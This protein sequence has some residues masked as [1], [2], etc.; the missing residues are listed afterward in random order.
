M[1]NTVPELLYH[2]TDYVVLEGILKNGIIRLCRSD[3]MNDSEEMKYFIK[4]LKE[5]TILKLKQAN[6]TENIIN[7]FEK[8]YEKQIKIRKKYICYLFSMTSLS[9]NA[10]Y[11]ERYGNH[12]KGIAIVFDSKVLKEISEEHMLSLKPVLYG[13]SAISKHILIQEVIDGFQKKFPTKN[14]LDDLKMIYD[15]VLA[16][17]IHFKN[18]S[19]FNEY[20][21]RL[22]SIPSWDDEHFR[23]LKLEVTT[24]ATPTQ[25]NKKVLLFNWKQNCD[26]KNIPYDKLINK[27]IIG[28]NSNQEDE[29]K[30][31]LK[32]NNL[33]CLIECVE[34]S[35]TP[36]Q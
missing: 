32:N 35:T 33:E 23:K 3:E 26:K 34:R 27:I 8:E 17:S 22:S 21:Y 30:L 11:W 4:K 18:S 20:E 9:D 28:K 10:F 12:K 29:V 14:K 15:Q 13:Y 5:C 6:Q 19:F 25:I 24:V 36:L 1:N 31:W 2:Y 16:C 7:L